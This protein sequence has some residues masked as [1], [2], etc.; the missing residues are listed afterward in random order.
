[1]LAIWHSFLQHLWMNL[2]PPRPGVAGT[3]FACWAQVLYGLL[4]DRVE[5]LHQRRTWELLDALADQMG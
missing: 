4:T 3:G 2:G 5:G 1:M